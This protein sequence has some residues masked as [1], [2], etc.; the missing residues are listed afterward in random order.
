[1]QSLTVSLGDRS[2]PIHIGQGLLRSS[3]LLTPHI[4]GKQ[5][6]I[7]TNETVAPLYVHDLEKTFS[8][9][10]LIKLI[11]PDG[12]DHKNLDTLARIYDF[13]LENNFSRS[14]TL[15]A[16]GGGVIGDICGFAAATYQR[17]IRYI[18]IPTTLL[19]Q[20]DSSVGG[21]TG[22]NRPLGKNMVGAFYQPQCVVIDTSTLTTLPDRELKAGLAEII[23]YGLINNLQFL[24]WL[25]SNLHE[26]LGRNPDSL[27]YAIQISCEEKA[28]IVA[29]DETEGGIRA[30]LNFGHTFGHAIETALGY[31]TWLHGEAVAAGMVMAAELSRRVGYLTENDV[32]KVKGLLELAGLPVNSPPID[33]A[34][35]I[36]LM[37]KDKK[38]QHGEMRFIL[39][40]SLGKA[41]IADD[42]PV[43]LVQ[44]TVS[45]CTK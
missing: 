42:I 10:D 13:L 12:E 3:K 27:Q 43:E 24:A 25:E 41:V 26:L 5:V 8:G 35:Y 17:G 4:N 40:K 15:V 20:V 32:Q 28:A 33:T 29:K 37:K 21:K 16:L 45:S 18:Q 1:M 38:A 39:L 22:V 7:V 44:E 11:L 34:T 23:K 6:C 19:S 2:Y 30:I 36:R 31:G 14:S 9:F